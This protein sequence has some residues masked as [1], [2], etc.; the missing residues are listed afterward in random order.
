MANTDDLNRAVDLAIAGDW[1][2]AHAIAQLDERDPLYR[3]LH[4]CLHKIEGDDFNSHYWYSG[5]G[6]TYNEFASPKTE[7]KAI[8]DA[9]QDSKIKK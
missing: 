4:A 7:L 2:G 9:L 3:W 8:R 5:S 1:D 6:H